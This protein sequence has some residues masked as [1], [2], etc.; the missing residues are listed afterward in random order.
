MC[1]HYE[2]LFNRRFTNSIKLPPIY[3]GKVYN[4]TLFAALVILKLL[5]NDDETWNEF[6]ENLN[7]L[8]DKYEFKDF[9]SMGFPEDWEIII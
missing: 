4:N 6:I 3:D 2:R 5:I 1:A 9:A 7:K 8:F